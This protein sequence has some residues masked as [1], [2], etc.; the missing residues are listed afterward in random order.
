MTEN[1]HRYTALVI[2]S[3]LN[4]RWIEEFASG[5]S[6]AHRSFLFT[7]LHCAPLR[8]MA[9]IPCLQVMALGLSL[10]QLDR[11]RRVPVEVLA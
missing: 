11:Q 10:E 2:I 8:D 6:L 1:L 4:V 5:D 9:Q 7:Y 3:N